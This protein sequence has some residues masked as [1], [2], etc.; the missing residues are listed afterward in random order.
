MK[1]LGDNQNADYIQ[2]T[3][4]GM[5]VRFAYIPEKSMQRQAQ[6][7]DAMRTGKAKVAE[8]T[9]EDLRE[10]DELVYMLQKFKEEACTFGKWKMDFSSERG[11]L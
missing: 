7:Y 11:Q 5:D 8:V 6:S 4:G 3:H 10:V 2:F 9:F 1:F